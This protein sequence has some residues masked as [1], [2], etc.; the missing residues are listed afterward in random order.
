VQR[1]SKKKLDMVMMAKIKVAPK[2]LNASNQQE[3][4]FPLYAFSFLSS[5]RGPKW[6]K[7]G[8]EE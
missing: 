4:F 1:K 8:R 7:R 2:K 5:V 3:V 6:W